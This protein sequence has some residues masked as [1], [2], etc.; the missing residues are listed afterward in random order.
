MIWQSSSSLAVRILRF[1][2]APLIEVFTDEHA[3]DDFHR[4]R[5]AP[6]DQRQAVSLAQIGADVLVQ[7]VI[8]QHTLESLEHGINLGGQ[9]GHA[10]KHVF[11]LVGID[12]HC[13]FLLSSTIA[14]PQRH[15][16]RNWAFTLTRLSPRHLPVFAPAA[17]S[18]TPEFRVDV[19]GWLH[20]LRPGTYER[21]A[22]VWAEGQSLPVRLIA[23]V[24]A[25]AQA[26]AL[27]ERK[28]RQARDKGRK[29]SEQAVFL[30]GFHL[31][32]TILPQKQWPLA[33]VLDL[34]ACRWQIEMV[35]RNLKS[36]MPFRAYGSTTGKVARN[37][38][39]WCP[40]RMPFSWN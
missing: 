11:G 31:L 35:F 4:R 18:T 7:L 32:V 10:S 2:I 8:F 38:W 40:W 19:V 23:V 39:R 1:P 27:H 5:M 20:E 15:P 16:R 36:E 3:Q 37:C 22:T 28:R 17:P 14:W 24:L 26:E 12:E 9:F 34:Y 13:F 30:A 25:E 21:R 29:L 6:M 33:L